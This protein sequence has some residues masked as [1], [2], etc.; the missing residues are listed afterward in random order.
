M[1][2]K[3]E[4]LKNFKNIKSKLLKYVNPLLRKEDFSPVDAIHISIL[5]LS[6]SVSTCG[7]VMKNDGYLMHRSMRTAVRECFKGYIALYGEQI[8]N[9]EFLESIL[10]AGTD[11][12]WL[13][14]LIDRWLRGKEDIEYRIDNICRCLAVFS[15]VIKT[16]AD[17]WDDVEEKMSLLLKKAVQGAK[18]LDCIL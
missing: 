9:K 4:A 1:D 17:T 13:S 12:D 5:F 14:D 15:S 10:E 16:D 8:K 11:T 7:I 18:E 3:E 6:A 2:S